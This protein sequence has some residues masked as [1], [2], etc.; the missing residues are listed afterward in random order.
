MRL[1]Y[2]SKAAEL[3][4]LA[5]WIP[6]PDSVAVVTIEKQPD[7]QQ[8]VEVQSVKGLKSTVPVGEL[9]QQDWSGMMQGI[10]RPDGILRDNLGNVVFHTIETFSMRYGRST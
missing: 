8:M 2:Q 9:A 10:H 6:T 5:F 4:Q 1:E 7:S 3:L